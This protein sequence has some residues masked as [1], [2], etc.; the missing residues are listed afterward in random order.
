VTWDAVQDWLWHVFNDPMRDNPWS[1]VGLVLIVA[2]GMTM[3]FLLSAKV[4]KMMFRRRTKGDGVQSDDKTRA[5][6]AIDDARAL[7][8][9]DESEL[10]QE[11]PGER[12]QAI[13]PAGMA[14]TGQNGPAEQVLYRSDP[15]T[16]SG[17][18]ALPMTS[19]LGEHRVAC[20][21]CE[22][23]GY[24]TRST[25]D[26]LRESLELI[27]DGGD[28]LVKEFYTRLLYAAPD[29]AAL[30]P[31]DLL[32]AATSDPNSGGAKQRDR[33]LGALIALANSYNLDDPAGMDRLD[34]ALGAFG[35]SHASF[36]RPDGTVQGATLEEYAAVKATLF[37]TLIAT[38]GPAW[39]P[40][41]TMAWS[42]AYDY[43]AAA[44][45]HEQ[46]RAGFRYP[47]APRS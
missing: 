20:E 21:H 36:A 40:S 47:R 13:R 31:A 15:M 23:T 16:D 19:G 12:L 5:A 2:G 28:M 25:N 41:F 26:L 44:M 22:G 8:G 7:H 27:G 32:T 30:F 42:E 17:V 10:G 1:V 39:K 11:A 6:E 35:R 46:H 24:V 4:G 33:L 34:T 38:A 43:A 45:M 18:H 14:A 29:L 3:L 9:E 37:G